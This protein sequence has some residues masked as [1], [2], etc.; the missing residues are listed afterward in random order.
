M[1]SQKERE[2]RSIFK[3]QRTNTFEDQGQS[4]EAGG[5]SNTGTPPMTTIS[6]EHKPQPG[7]RF[8]W[9]HPPMDFLLGPLMLAA[10]ETGNTKR[11]AYGLECIRNIN[12]A[13]HQKETALHKAAANGHEDIVQ[14]LLN[15]GASA[16]AMN[17]SGNTPLHCA[18]T[19]G[20]TSTVE[21]LLSK[22]ASIAAMSKANETPLH[23]AVKG[24]HTS[25][26]EILLLNGASIEATDIFSNTPL[27]LAARDG[28]TSTVEL[29]LT[30]GALTEAVNSDRHTPLHLAT[31]RRRCGV[32]E[33]LR[34]KGAKLAI[35]ETC[36]E[37]LDSDGDNP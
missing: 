8:S 25:I 18:A 5:S 34:S 31:V 17:E 16:K 20:H 12:F 13:D 7:S 1:I 3:P 6:T 32:A 21:L 33:L 11:V 15:K 29:L 35:L 14:I 24:G 28:H 37:Y 9:A 27:H 36:E 19:G 26:A 4:S 2:I 22:R 10:A 23:S 30:K